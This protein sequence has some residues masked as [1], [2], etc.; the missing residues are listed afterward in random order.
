MSGILTGLPIINL[1]LEEEVV[2]IR[3]EFEQIVFVR[4]QTEVILSLPEV[5]HLAQELH[6]IYKRL[7]RISDEQ[8][9]VFTTG[10]E[11]PY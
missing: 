10:P 2:S 9:N 1:L 8:D 11:Y 6:V 3:I 7:R 5:E 4:E